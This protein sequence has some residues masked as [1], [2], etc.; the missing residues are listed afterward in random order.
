MYQK[1]LEN[2]YLTIKN[3]GA[4]MALRQALDPGQYWLHL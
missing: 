4:S 2:A 1:K 3:A